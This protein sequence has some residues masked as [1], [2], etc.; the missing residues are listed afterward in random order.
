MRRFLEIINDLRLRDM[1]LQGGPFTWSGGRNG[2]S[3]SRLDRFL[4]TT[5]W[6]IQFSKEV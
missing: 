1:S 4:V 3:M 2:R 5:D 6:E